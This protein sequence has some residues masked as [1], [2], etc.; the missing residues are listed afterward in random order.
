MSNSRILLA[1]AFWAFVI[2][3]LFVSG[4]FTASGT[5]SVSLDASVRLLI[6]LVMLVILISGGFRSRE[7]RTQI[8]RREA[9]R[10]HQSPRS[11]PHQVISEP[12]INELNGQLN[13]NVASTGRETR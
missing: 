13:V 12:G 9:L 4:S 2:V 11:M 5:M 1:S 8:R 3:S 7:Q 6:W 10:L